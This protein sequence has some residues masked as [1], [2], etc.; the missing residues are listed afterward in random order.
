MTDLLKIQFKRLNQLKL[1]YL[2]AAVMAAYILSNGISFM[3]EGAE[4]AGGYYAGG[5]FVSDC[6]CC[7]IDIVGP[8]F[9]ALICA[10]L[11]S[12]ERSAGMFKQPL[13]TGISKMELIMAKTMSVITVAFACFLFTILFSTVVG[14]FFWGNEVFENASECL[15]RFWLLALPHITISLFWVFL[16]LYMNLPG[17]LCASLIILLI[18][19]LFS[20]FFWKVCVGSGFY[21]LFLC[22]FRI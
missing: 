13:L 15:L 10:V 22:F 3:K 20:Q 7:Y 21:V 8:L 11:I 19:N 2:Y 4:E 9:L 17:M 5:M 12:S 18:N 1:V 16:S 14:C 6:I